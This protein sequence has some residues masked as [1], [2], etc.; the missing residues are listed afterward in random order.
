MVRQ[1]AESTDEE[2]QAAAVRHLGP[3]HPDTLT[4]RANLAY[5]R[6]AAGDRLGRRPLGRLLPRPCEPTRGRRLLSAVR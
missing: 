1:G 5:W 6:G 4:T 3:D 2:M